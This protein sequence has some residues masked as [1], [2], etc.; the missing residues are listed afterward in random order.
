[1]LGIAIGIAA[2]ILLT[3]IGEGTRLYMVAQFT[4]F[5]TNLIAINPGKSKTLG[6][7]G[8]LGGTTHKFTIDDAE[9]LRASPASRPW[10]RSSWAPRASRRASAAAA[11][12]YRGHARH[13]DG[14]GV[15]RAPGRVL[16]GGRSAARRA[17]GRARARSSRASCSASEAPSA[18]RP[19]RRHPLPRDR[20]HG[21][22]GP[23]ARLRPRR[24]GLRAGRHRHAPLQP[25]RAGRDRPHL[26]A[27]RDAGARRGEVQAR[28]PSATA[29]R[30]TSR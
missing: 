16:A 7:P 11:S 2:V 23:D 17:G 14:A 18:S 26:P 27:R 22:Q 30:R 4:Q 1:M 13:P 8:V 3:S 20:G 12:S 5:G 15:R 19:R 29:A 9:A 24:H 21:A 28:S 6:M 10:C 25:R